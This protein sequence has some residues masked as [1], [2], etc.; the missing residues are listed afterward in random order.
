MTATAQHCVIDQQLLAGLRSGA[1]DKRQ[2]L[3]LEPHSSLPNQFVVNSMDAVWRANMEGVVPANG[4]VSIFQ[5]DAVSDRADEMGYKLVFLK[6]PSATFRWMESLSQVPEISLLSEMPNTIN[7]FLPFQVQGF[8]MLKQLRA[9]FAHWSTGTGKTVLAS[10]LTKYHV[11]ERNADLVVWVVKTHNKINTSR[12]ILAMV[13]MDS[14]VVDGTKAKRQKIYGEV[15]AALDDR[16]AQVVVT[17]YEKFRDDEDEW[18]RLVEGRKVFFVFDEMPTKLRNRSIKMYKAVCRVLYTSMTQGGHPFPK[19]G[20]ER[21]LELR[22]LMLSA[23]PVENSIEDIF[24]CIR[25]MDPTVYKSVAEFEKLHVN[26]TPMKVKTKRGWKWIDVVDSYKNFDVLSQ[27]IAHMT[28]QADKDN[29]PAI[30]AQFPPIVD[31]PMTVDF[32]DTERKLYDK[33]LKEFIAMQDGQLSMLDRTD[34][35]AAIGAFQMICDNP[36][37]VPQSAAKFEEWDAKYQQ[38]LRDLDAGLIGNADLRRIE[39][40]RAGSLV[41]KKLADAVDPA[42]FTDTGADG[43]ATV[44]KLIALKD[45]LDSNEGEK[46]IIFTTFNDAGLPLLSKWLTKWG[47][48]HVVYHG[49]QSMAQKQAAEDR[50]TTD[51]NCKVF[52]SS[53]SGSD[54]INLDCANLVVHY[55]LPWKWSTLTQRQNRAHRITSKFPQVRF[56]R[57]AIANSIEDRKQYILDTKY[58][59]HKAVMEGKIAEQS[60][61]LRGKGELLY[62]LTGQKDTDI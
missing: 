11:E 30:R 38:A 8:N 59:Y 6:D 18:A 29:D 39:K 41:C 19:R 14:T 52:L 58:G 24:N 34:L 26:K 60:T 42:L 47:Y 56:F 16:F 46:A 44:S 15:G 13:G 21:P 23:T 51:P 10:A 36:V 40:E 55:D 62:I 28:H 17:N 45:I 3:F 37:M 32:S 25:L 12:A 54:S 43:E 22:T 31:T 20:A 53:D 4:V 27:R 1:L 7:G 48:D 9:A 50:F 5:L 49:G 61:A 2:Y 57:L 33:L 35:L